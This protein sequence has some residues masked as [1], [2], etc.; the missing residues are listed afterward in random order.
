M[1]PTTDAEAD[2]TAIAASAPAT[3]PLTAQTPN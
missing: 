3:F 1:T 2:E